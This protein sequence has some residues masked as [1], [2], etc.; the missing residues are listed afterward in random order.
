MLIKCFYAC[1]NIFYV[2]DIVQPVASFL[3]YKQNVQNAHNY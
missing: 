1:I 2:P 3:S